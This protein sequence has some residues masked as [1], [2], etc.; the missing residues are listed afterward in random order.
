ME[1]R[2]LKDKATE[3]FTKGRFSK[4][5]E[6]YEEY[7]RADPKD[8]QSR[9]RT[10]DAWAKAGQRERAVAAYQAAAE[11]FAKEGF[12]PRAIAA[13]KLILELDPA[14]RGVQQM[15]ADLYARRAAPAGAKARGP[16]GS[17]L[18]TPAPTAEPAAKSRLPEEVRAA[19]AEI[20]LDVEVDG[21]AAPESLEAGGAPAELS[22]DT[23]AGTEEVVVHSVRVGL[24]GTEG[25]RSRSAEVSLDVEVADEPIL[26]GEPVEEA[27]ETEPVVVGQELAPEPMDSGPLA[28]P[29]VTGPAESPAVAAAPPAPA[30]APA[31]A[32]SARPATSSLPPGLAPRSSQRVSGPAAPRQPASPLP[33]A[34][35]PPA[36][37]DP[38]S[39]K[40]TAL[41]SPIADPA[42]QGSGPASPPA[43]VAA[44]APPAAAPPGLRPRR[45][46]PQAPAGATA[47]PF[48]E[49]SPGLGVSLRA[50]AGPSSFTE[51]ELEADSLLHA[52]ELAAQAGVSQRAAMSVPASVE[53]EEEVYSLTE[54]VGPEGRS[55]DD[56]PTVPLF[57]DLPRD[58]FIELFERCP[59]R[60]FGPGERI[61][62]QGTRGDAFYVICEGSVRVF[63]TDGGQRQDLA[64]LEGGACFGEMALLSG[65]P[66]TASVEGASEDTQLL[67]ISA[68]V[69]AELSRRYPLVAQALKKFVRQRMLTNVMNTSA[70]FRPFNRKDRRT[71]VERFRARDVE[72]DAV[73][74]RDGDATDGL[75]VVLSGEVEVRKDGLL[76]T[77]LKEGDLFGEISLLQKTPATATV[78]ATRHTTL[79]RLPREDF[80]L[81][82]SSHP[83]IL[84]LISEL[85]DERLLRTQRVLGAAASGMPPEGDEDLIL[86]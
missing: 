66:R 73:I 56:L 59:L 21:P 81:L 20:D 76:L 44:E 30:S 62:E 28:A 36:A 41:A 25:A 85:S 40:W 15:L 50:A 80:D 63:R 71:L 8:H 48:P 54:E 52:V 53:G 82:I 9:L 7:C 78:T 45:A 35:P 75:Y 37:K 27:Q 57:S 39:R 5:A 17:V 26:V 16:M 61:I 12:L 70:L 58:A 18:S 42:V 77:R 19:V 86:V 34:P 51:L 69:L 84:V 65:A 68:P 83:Q 6:L 46:E 4:A 13:S 11:G 2:K 72:R 74:I 3:A 49:L 22:L 79:L 10:G 55:L 1:L 60:R 29:V 64:T 32:V 14:H 38:I 43:P 23:S 31:P 24:E 33:V 47:L 67:E